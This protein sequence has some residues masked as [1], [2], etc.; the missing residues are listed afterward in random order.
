MITDG[1]EPPTPPEGD[2]YWD[3][4][5]VGPHPLPE[6]T[7]RT[8][9]SPD[10][11]DAPANPSSNASSGDPSF[12][13]GSYAVD[14]VH[15]DRTGNR[16][17]RRKNKKEVSLES[18]AVFATGYGCATYLHDLLDVPHLS[19]DT[20][21]GPIGRMVQSLDDKTEA[22][23]IGMYFGL[24]QV[25]GLLFGPHP[26]VVVGGEEHGT[27]FSMVLCGDTG[28]GRKGTTLGVVLRIP[29]QLGVDVTTW[30]VSGFGSGEGLLAMLALLDAERSDG[31]L[32]PAGSALI[33]ADEFSRVI[34]AGRRD[35]STLHDVIRELDGRRPLSH[36]TKDTHHQIMDHH[37][38]IHGHITREELR[39]LKLN[40]EIFGGLANRMAWVHVGSAKIKTTNDPLDYEGFG[41]AVDALHKLI[42]D[43]QNRDRVMFT[44]A[45]QARWAE[46]YTALRR[47]RVRGLVGAATQ[48]KGSTALRLALVHALLDGATR[49]GVK[50]VN[51]AVTM[52]LYALESAQWVFGDDLRG[53]LT[54]EILEILSEERDG[55]TKTQLSRRIGYDRDLSD[56]LAELEADGRI[57]VT[58]VATTGRPATRIRLNDHVQG[59][60]IDGGE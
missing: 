42:L 39:A 26:H 18:S 28:E 13:D 8:R 59:L 21:S 17:R 14:P 31:V 19:L 25:A 41:T 48:R 29:E 4:L 34:R 58:K 53:D 38:A 56:A 12:N 54:E 3:N 5:T 16:A 30:V 32:C 2:P 46:C 7:G 22:D 36:H 43:A 11:E 1:Y 23:P 35:T 40:T 44:P 52:I 57:V 37:V 24:V 10:F 45:G 60:D 50:H 27:K 51:A 47:T 33:V 9:P 20:M 15:H 6:P 49:I 55:Q